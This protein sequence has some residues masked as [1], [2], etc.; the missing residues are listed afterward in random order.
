MGKNYIYF[1]L[2]V[3]IFFNLFFT[4][5][6]LKEGFPNGGDTIGHYDLVVNTRDVIKIFFSTGELRLWNTDYYFGF[7]LFFFY[8]PLPYVLLASLSLLTAF[9]ALLLVKLSIV[10]LFSFFPLVMYL[11]A[12]LMELEEKYALCIAVFSTTLSSVTVFGLEY[13]AFF[14]TGLFSQL[15]ATVLFPLAFA[16]SYRYFILKKGNPFY[17]V[18][19]LFLTFVSHLL[20]GFIA[21]MSAGLLFLL[22][23]L[24]QTERKKLLWNGAIIFLFF[25]LSISGFLI[26]YLLNQD[27]FGNITADLQQK[28]QG[29]GFV[30]TIS[31]LLD[32]ELLDYSV[33]FS[34]VPI[35]TFLFFFG[36]LA[37]FFRKEF[38]EK[39]RM[40]SLFLFIAFLFSLIAVAGKTSF[41]LLG[42]IPVLSTLQTF[43][44]IFLF[45]FVS[46]FYIGLAL[47][48]LWTLFERWNQPSL[49]FIILLIITAPVFYERMQT[50]KKYSITY[51]LFTEPDYSDPDYWR[52][53]TAIKESTLHMRTSI[54]S[55]TGLLDRP[56]QLQ[57]LPILTGKPIFVSTSIGAH[58]TLSAYYAELPLPYELADLFAVDFLIEG[59]EKNLTLVTTKEPTGYFSVV[60]VPFSID[61]RALDARE[62]IV[63]W[64]FSNASIAGHYLE[65][66]STESPIVIT[67]IQE[68]EHFVELTEI[69]TDFAHRIHGQILLENAPLVTIVLPD[70]E[71]ETYSY[72]YFQAYA[73]THTSRNCGTV[74][75][76]TYARGYY[77][78]TVFVP[79]E[80]CFLLF[81]MS[82]HP[83][84]KVFVD[85]K[86][87]Q[88]RMLSPSFMGVAVHAGTHD[89]VFS[90]EVFWYRI[91]LF[92]V[93]I[94]SLILLYTFRNTTGV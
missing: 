70:A 10:L 41:P 49:F 33:S 86:E 77:T 15:W 81:K 52:V 48:G 94:F 65:I 42:K 7:P 46:L 72:D 53:V 56:Q 25:F 63:A 8:A 20:I 60:S 3:V 69:G 36:T 32:G 17:P 18:F 44:F 51:D 39:Y 78:A 80:D 57:A 82:Y 45:H 35:L 29:F 38:C 34:R 12:R 54:H 73:A 22:M 90:Y 61:A 59:K 23:L 27:Y 14:A 79:E 88:L 1:I 71:F 31:L 74:Q 28:E 85:G 47:W 9:D 87:E 26:P 66:E 5:G 84:W 75:N 58:D 30:Q 40:L 19:F 83:E 62:L 24:F 4:A 91:V 43:R 21:G 93:G 6:I 50:F 67:N 68:N 37:S 55:S 16:F 92:I 2:A 13:Y 11:A 76:E 89:V 64:I